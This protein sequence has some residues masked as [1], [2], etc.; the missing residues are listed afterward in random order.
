MTIIPFTHDSPEWHAL[1]AKNIGASEVAAL[2]GMQPAYALDHF[3]LHHVKAGNAPPPTVDGPRV[4]WGLRLE[5]VVADAVAEEHGVSISKGG[6]AMAD[7]CPGMG[8]SLDFIVQS[9]V[10]GEF[11]GHGLLE[12]KNTDW[13]VHKRTWID[14]EP[15][16]HVLL[17]LQQQLGCTGY[18]WG[19]VAALVGGNDLRIYRYAARPKLI[20]DIKTRITKFWDNV[21]TG[22]PPEV[23]GSE[24]SGAIL[25]ALFPDPIDDVVDLS[26]SNEWPE[27]VAAFVAAGTANRSAK[28]A[29]DEAKNRVVALLGNHKRG[30]GG[31][32]SVNTSII[33]AKLD[34][35]AKPGEII[36]GKAEVRRYTGKEISA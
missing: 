19:M 7:D 16:Y 34:R 21:R 20:A 5:A 15:P 35:P 2:F 29:Y 10:S 25:R 26:S 31:G 8:A 33:P 22:R 18:T 13:L 11:D 32:W 9:D 30:F 28:D 27:A 4:K 36:R 23:S 17:Q 14:G 24:S 3:S 6:Y 12:T 1:R